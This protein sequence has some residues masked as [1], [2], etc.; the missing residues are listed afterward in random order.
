M[1]ENDYIE[2]VLK[3]IDTIKTAIQ[4]YHSENQR[5][6]NENEYLKNMYENRVNEYLKIKGE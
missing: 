3:S 6:R 4:Y 5:L 2:N 1:N